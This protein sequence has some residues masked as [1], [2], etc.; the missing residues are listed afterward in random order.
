MTHS[1]IPP[2][3]VMGVQGSG[4]TTVGTLLAARLGAVFVDGDDLHPEHNRRLMAAGTPLTDTERLPWLRAVGARLAEGGD[5]GIVMACS[6]LK[7]S[8]RDLLRSFAPDSVMVHPHGPMEVVAER[9]AGRTHQFMPP[10]LLMS[11]YEVLETLQQDETGVTID[12]A[13]PLERIVDQAVE[14]VEGLPGAGGGPGGT[15]E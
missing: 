14:F 6:A 4:K 13:Q 1:P 10:A 7:R 3:V 11:Q 8:Y 15:G 2:L 9:V 5:G 12:L